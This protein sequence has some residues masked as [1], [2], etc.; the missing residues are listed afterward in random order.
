MKRIDCWDCETNKN[1]YVIL[2]SKISS[3]KSHP[4]IAGNY[5]CGILDFKPRMVDAFGAC[6]L[7]PLKQ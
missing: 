7:P 3:A 1:A 2:K 6:M 5:I 4:E